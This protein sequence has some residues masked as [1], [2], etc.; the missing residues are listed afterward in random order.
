MNAFDFSVIEE[1]DPS[2]SEGHRV[3]YD[4]EVPFEIRNQTDPH[5]AAQEVGTLEAIKVKILV[6]GD[7]ANPLTL[8]I[9]LTSENDLFF[10]F[11]HNLDEH[12]FRQVQEHQKLMVDFPEYSN[13]LI[14]MLN[15]C[16]KEPHS[17]LAVFVIEREGLARLDFIQNMEYKFVELLSC[18]FIASPEDVIRAHICFRY[19]TLKSRLALVQSRLQ[20]IESL[21]KVK[22][23]SLLLQLTKPPSS[24]QARS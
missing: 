2:V 12:G 7:V 14:R 1:H 8:R 23:P 19:N 4:R 16:I 13:V 10:H 11:N 9:E 15:N 17:H 6:M 24:R 22:N 20:D 18:N 3:L 5:D 21:I